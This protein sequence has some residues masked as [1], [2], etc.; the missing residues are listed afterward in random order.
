MVAPAF[1]EA[2]GNWAWVASNPA[3]SWRIRGLVRK[4]EATAAHLLASSQIPRTPRNSVRGYHLWIT[5]HGGGPRWRTAALQSHTPK[6]DPCSL[7]C[8]HGLMDLGA[9]LTLGKQRLLDRG[10][11][12]PFL[13]AEVLLQH[14]LGVEKVY[15]L[16]HPERPLSREEET[17]YLD[18]LLRRASGEPAQYIT[19][20]QEFW[21][22]DFLV[23]PDVLIPRP[24]TEHVVE[25]VLQLRREPQPRIVDVGTG[26]GCIAISLAKEIPQARIFAVDNSKQA[27]QVAARNAESL[28]V[29]ERVEFRLGDLLS[30]FSLD[31]FTSAFDFVVSNPPYVPRAERVS[32]QAEVKNHEPL[33][34]LHS[35]DKEPFEIY[36]RLIGQAL[37]RLCP[38]GYLVMEM[39]AGQED[40]IRS[41]FKSD[42]WG[43]VSTVPD[44]QSIPRVIFAKKRDSG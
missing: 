28:G 13:N 25:T 36:R 6:V 35:P 33:S 10:V 21:G 8:H 18:W 14:L 39:G 19:G 24:E 29:C 16:S 32:L 2:G 26:S 30:P 12:S 5:N 37:P 41:L 20:H 22:L 44:L 34:A 38:G 17:Q 43:P 3:V 11:P 9:A 4:V 7:W 40:G 42:G 27:L 31:E 15:L 1:F 23:T